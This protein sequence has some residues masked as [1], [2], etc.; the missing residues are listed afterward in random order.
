LP[1]D[2]AGVRGDG[3]ARCGRSILRQSGIVQAFSERLH[4]TI[5]IW[6]EDD[7]RHFTTRTLKKVETE[8]SLHVLAYNMKRAIRVL[9]T[10][11]LIA[12]FQG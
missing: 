6:N 5:T 1:G 9:G 3:R 10:G 12:A 11:K 8:M 4:E 7:Q 2:L